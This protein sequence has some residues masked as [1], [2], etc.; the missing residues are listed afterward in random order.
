MSGEGLTICC[1][2]SGDFRGPSCVSVAPFGGVLPYTHTHT[3]TTTTTTTRAIKNLC[4]DCGCG[5]YRWFGRSPAVE[6]DGNHILCDCG[7]V[8]DEGEPKQFLCDHQLP[9]LAAG[10]GKLAA[11]IAV[12]HRS[13]GR[14]SYC[15]QTLAQGKERAR[16]R[17]KIDVGC[18]V[19]CRQHNTH[20]HTT[21]LIHPMIYYDNTSSGFCI[22][23]STIT[24]PYILS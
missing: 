16:E 5:Y 6:T 10:E 19:D 14:P 20:T 23:S 13:S 11:D 7:V 8:G 3:T 22:Q 2:A 18:K 15:I 1:C 21:T 17:R 9:S 4:R 12:V 24:F